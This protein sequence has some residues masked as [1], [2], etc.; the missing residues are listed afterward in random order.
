MKRGCDTPTCQRPA[1]KAKCCS[2]RLCDACIDTHRHPELDAIAMDPKRLA[3]WRAENAP[4]QRLTADVVDA[5]NQVPGLF[6]WRTK[7][8][9]RGGNNEMSGVLD[10]SGVAAPDGRAFYVETKKVHPDACTCPSCVDQRD[11]AARVNGAG[12]VA[13]LGA[14]TVSQAVDG[15]RMGLARARGKSEAA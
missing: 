12:G 9:R 5:L 11:F 15:V 8:G 10:V 14:R 6:A 1:T 7:L 2:A 13:V 4:E 3:Q